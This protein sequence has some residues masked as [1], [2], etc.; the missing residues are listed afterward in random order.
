[1]ATGHAGETPTPVMAATPVMAVTGVAMT[2]HDRRRDRH[3]VS[4]VTGGPASMAR[5]RGLCGA[6][7]ADDRPA[8]RWAP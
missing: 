7:M 1:M 8:A 3:W 2:G 5:D 6:A 4:A